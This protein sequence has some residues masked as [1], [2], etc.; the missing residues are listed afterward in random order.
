MAREGF[1]EQRLHSV[2][3]QLPRTD[4][5]R[6]GRVPK[7]TDQLGLRTRIPGAD[8]GNEGDRHVVES[9]VEIGEEP[10]REVVRPGNVVDQDC[11]W[12]L[13]GE[14]D[15]QPVQAMNDTEDI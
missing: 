11:Q 12:T 13:V 15:G 8:R 10:Q 1:G 7:M 14:V 9:F 3:A 6:C 2:A 5:W 4:R